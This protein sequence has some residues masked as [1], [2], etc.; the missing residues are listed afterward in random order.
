MSWVIIETADYGVHIMPEDEEH[1]LV[2]CS[3]KFAFFESSCAFVH[4]SFDGRE[5]YENGARKP[6]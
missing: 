4:N 1:D 6:H 2:D 3:C 5:A